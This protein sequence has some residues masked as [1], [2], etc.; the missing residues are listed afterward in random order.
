MSKEFYQVEFSTYNSESEL[1]QNDNELLTQAKAAALKAYAPYSTFK[2]GAAVRLANGKIVVG[3]NQE[4]AAYPSGL[5]AERVALFYANSIYPDVAPVAIAI[6]AISDNVPIDEPITPCGAC[7]QVMAEFEK[8]G[9]N[10]LKVIMQGQKGPVLI[11][12]SM[13]M[14]L[15]FSFADDI[16]LKYISR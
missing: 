10:N 9:G 11:T 3:N 13:K 16:L 12:N 2:V 6:T 1:D 14:L 8:K 7:R 5:C 4:N 15:P